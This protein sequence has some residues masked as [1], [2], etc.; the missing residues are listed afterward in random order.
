L[1]FSVIVWVRR[2]LCAPWALFTAWLFVYGMP[3][4]GLHAAAGLWALWPSVRADDAR[5]QRWAAIAVFAAAL[6]TVPTVGLR[7]YADETQGF[8][9]RTLG[10]MGTDPAVP[11]GWRPGEV[12]D[13]GELAVGARIAREGGALFSM[14]ERLAIH[15]FNHV[16][17]SG[18]VLT[19][20]W[21]V[22]ALTL[23]MSWAEDPFGDATRATTAERRLQCRASYPDGKDARLAQPLVWQDDFPMRSPEVRRTL[24]AGIRA[25]PAQAGA[26]RELGTVHWSDGG[27]DDFAG[28]ARALKTDAFSVAVTLEVGDS[29]LSVT[30][31]A[32]GKVG[33]AWEGT[34][35]YPGVDVAFV[36]PLPLQRRFLRVSETAFCGMSADGAMNPYALR[37]HWVLD[38]DD[39]RL[40]PEN[41]DTPDRTLFEHVVG[42]TVLALGA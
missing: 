16:L 27:N 23:H 21:E 38:E 7:E 20:F 36:Q 33:A 14:R 5:G 30:R 12:C 17:A 8:H 22:A 35:H 40:A 25:L 31:R 26:T 28:Y 13:P 18:G 42:A 24:V 9:C 34:I 2:L 32:D 41:V 15:G 1:I 39:P 6:V 10:F 4:S 11:R 3:L 19:G 37:I 29:R